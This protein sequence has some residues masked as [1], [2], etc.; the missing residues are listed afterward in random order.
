M[1]KIIMASF[2]LLIFSCSSIENYFKDRNY[3][4]Y[5]ENTKFETIRKNE[6]KKMIE[7]EKKVVEKTK[8]IEEVIPTIRKADEIITKVEKPKVENIEAPKN[9]SRFTS[10]DL[11]I[12]KFISS[13]VTEDEK[14]IQKLVDESLSI[15]EKKGKKYTVIEFLAM[16]DDIISKKKIKSFILINARLMNRLEK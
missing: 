12:I 5:N 3:Y 4:T 1:K 8:K 11:Q 2:S 14:T 9:T 7:T 13:K 10:D 6:D 16:A 15:L